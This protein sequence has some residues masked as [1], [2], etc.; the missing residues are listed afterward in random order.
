MA[1]KHNVGAIGITTGLKSVGALLSGT[2]AKAYQAASSISEERIKQQFS[3][4]QDLAESKIL[5]LN[6]TCQSPYY[7]NYDFNNLITALKC[8]AANEKLNPKLLN[9]LAL[10]LENNGY[11]A[12]TKADFDQ[13]ARAASNAIIG[14]SVVTAGLGSVVD[15]GAAVAKRFTDEFSKAITQQPWEGSPGDVYGKSFA[16][17]TIPVA[18]TGIASL[19]G[20]RLFN[21]IKDKISS[22]YIPD[23]K[24]LDTSICEREKLLT[25]N[26]NKD[27]D[28]CI[29]NT[30]K[31]VIQDIKAKFD[32]TSEKIIS[33]SSDIFLNP[34][35]ID[36][37][38]FNFITFSLSNGAPGKTKRNIFKNTIKR[39][40][41]NTIFPDNQR[42]LVQELFE[43][44]QLRETL[45]DIYNIDITE[46]QAYIKSFSIE[47]APVI[48][49]LLLKP[50]TSEEISNL[51]E[52]IKALKQRKEEESRTF[53]GRSNQSIQCFGD[54]CKSAADSVVSAAKEG[55]GNVFKGISNKG[56]RKSRKLRKRKTQKRRKGRKTRRHN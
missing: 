7:K 52:R 44:K 56:G 39:H 18:T 45:F 15:S 22:E 2:A 6:N 14:A 49:E 10:F 29:K 48:K 19:Y 5:E 11:V 9:K 3:K 53:L 20:V 38:D 40:C 54:A 27:L 35:T 42:N 34:I 16:T 4:G 1:D 41:I 37:D 28:L 12:M 36:K 30:T 23:L 43:L 55:L 24:K 25:P 13:R 32:Q 31:Q 46:K 50:I 51:T 17:G 26:K 21:S 47:A 33:Y 8:A